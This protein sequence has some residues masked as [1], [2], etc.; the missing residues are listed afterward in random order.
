MTIG[1]KP[2]FITDANAMA[3]MVQAM[4]PNNLF[5]PATFQSAIT[6]YHIVIANS[7]LKA[8]SPVPQINLLCAARLMGLNC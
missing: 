5:R 7:I 2:T 6:A 3:V 4:G 8:S 1:I